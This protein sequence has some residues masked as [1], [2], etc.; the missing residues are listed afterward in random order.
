MYPTFS[1]NLREEHW[2]RSTVPWEN[3]MN[4]SVSG[5]KRQSRRPGDH[6]YKLDQASPESIATFS[7]IASMPLG[8]HPQQPP[9]QFTPNLE[10][11]CC[12]KRK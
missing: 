10:H 3:Y 4:L 11:T 2:S 12:E 6:C 1:P 5:K 8:P 9:I 7:A